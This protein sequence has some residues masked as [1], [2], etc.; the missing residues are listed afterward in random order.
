MYSHLFMSVL[1]LMVLHYFLQVSLYGHSLGSVLSY[2]I[3]CHQESL[4]VPF[5]TEYLNMDD[6][7]TLKS[8]NT[9][10]VHDL[11]TKEHN[12][13]TLGHSCTDNI[14]GIADEGN[15]T[16][17]SH[18]DDIHASC[19]LENEPKD[20]NTSASPIAVDQEQ[21]EV[22]SKA[23]SYQITYPEEEAV[24][25]VRTKDIDVSNISRSV[26]E[27]HEQV[28]DKDNLIASL[29]QEVYMEFD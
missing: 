23:E 9:P 6:G 25:D 13:A 3:L 20:D 28:L 26:E 21:K 18:T 4:S 17:P 7:L 12:A 1:L 15:I 5:P 27:V 19:M 10:D 22:E 29:E 11:S 16:D 8:P 24:P 14:N 2:D